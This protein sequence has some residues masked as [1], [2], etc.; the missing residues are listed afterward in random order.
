MPHTGK[1]LTFSIAA[2]NI[3]P[4]FNRLMDSLCL[5]NDKLR[6]KIEVLIVNDGSTDGTVEKARE[7]ERLYP[8][9]VRLIDKENGG[10]GSTINRGIDEASGTYFRALDGDD[11]LDSQN[12]LRLVLDLEEIDADLVVNDYYRAYVLEDS[13][14][15]DSSAADSSAACLPGGFRYEKESMAGVLPEG[16]FLFRDVCGKIDYLQYHAIIYRT[17]MLKKYPPR[18]QEHCFFVDIEYGYFPMM[19]VK[20][21]VYLPYPLYC[22]RLGT[23]GQS[24]S[25]EGRVKHIGDSRRVLLRIAR[26]YHRNRDRLPEGVA[27]YLFTLIDHELLWYIDSHMYR[28]FQPGEAGEVGAVL[29]EIQALIPDFREKTARGRLRFILRRSGRGSNYLFYRAAARLLHSY[30]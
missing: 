28:R 18:L 11:F 19:Y 12:L 23:S 3:S 27:N 22:Y 14:A 25:A 4:Y 21:A 15:A 10:H 6:E 16:K 1:I 29:R 8:G 2:Y 30:V 26:A 24:M 13:T 20:T 9:T 7:Y 17:E 5:E